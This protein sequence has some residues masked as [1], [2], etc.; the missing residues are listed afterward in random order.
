[1]K[2]PFREICEP[3][4]HLMRGIKEVKQSRS[5]QR[6]IALTLAVG[7]E[8]NRSNIKSFDLNSLLKLSSI[9]GPY[10][11]KCLTRRKKCSPDSTSKKS[12][13]H[14]L[15][16]SLAD[17]E[18]QLEC[19][20]QQFHH[21]SLIAKTDFEEVAANLDHMEGQCKNSLGYL[22]LA[23]TYD[24]TTE[25]LVG[26]FLEEAVKEM[27]GLRLVMDLVTELFLDLLNWLGIPASRHADFTPARLASVLT[28]FSRSLSS[29]ITVRRG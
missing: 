17:S 8:M 23:A 1:M 6:V 21:F 2:V 29:F 9:K 18:E 27:V 16:K 12:L 22:R 11:I 10:W 26:E 7:N 4:S 13:L 25:H 28:E 24:R 5:L 3:Y 19:L 20:S 15:V 14:F